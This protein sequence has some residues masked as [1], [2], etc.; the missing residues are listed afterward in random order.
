[1][2]RSSTLDSRLSPAAPRPRRSGKPREIRLAWTEGLMWD[3]GTPCNGGLWHIDT[4][5]RR[6]ELEHAVHHGRR[7][8]GPNSHWLEE[9]DA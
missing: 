4:P 2:R 3:D 5:A 7:L 9:R 6:A 8:F 1:M